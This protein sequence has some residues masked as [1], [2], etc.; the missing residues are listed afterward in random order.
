MGRD[1]NKIPYLKET[2]SLVWKAELAQYNIC[3]SY[4][5]NDNTYATKW[6]VCVCDV[7]QCMWYNM[8]KV[9]YFCYIVLIFFHFL[10]FCV[11][12]SLAICWVSEIFKFIHLTKFGKFHQCFLKY[13]FCPIIFLP[14]LLGLQ[15]HTHT[16]KHTQ[17]IFAILP[18]ILRALLRYFSFSSD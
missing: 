13:F 1:T 18:Q 4:I 5:H 11:Y 6:Y 10:A 17:E 15:I 9:K 8:Y 2:H 16:H 14:S 3:T 12:I 7:Y